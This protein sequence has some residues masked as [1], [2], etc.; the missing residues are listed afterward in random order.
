MEP[1]HDSLFYMIDVIIGEERNRAMGNFTNYV[2]P[3][4]LPKCN[5]VLLQGIT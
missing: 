4:I 5:K 1:S 2:A 3:N